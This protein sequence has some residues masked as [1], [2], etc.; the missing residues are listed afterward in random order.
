MK[1]PPSFLDEIRA[2]LPLSEVVG[3]SVKLKKEGREWRG[4]S[5]FNAEKTPSFYVNDQ[6]GFFH[7]FSAQRNGDHFAFIMETQGLSFPDAVEKL[8]GMAGLAM[9]TESPEAA[10]A[11][12]R[13]ATT[14]EAAELAAAFFEQQLRGPAGAAARAYLTE[15]GLGAEA[16][17]K[18]RLGYSPRERY[19]LR[20]HLA[21]KG[22]SAETMIEAGL[23]THGHEINVPYDFF[24]DRLMFPICDRRGRVI[25]FGGRALAKDAQPKYK[26]TSETPLFHKGSNLYNLHNARE[27]AQASGTVIAVE[28]YIDVIAMDMA[29]HKNV[30][31][32][33]GTALTPDQCELLWKMA[34]EPILC[35]DGDKA[36]RK[37]AFR[38]VDTALPLIGAGKSLRFALLPE[39]QDPDDLARS[40][41]GAA[42]QAVLE[43]SKPLAE[44][45]FLREAEA[46]PLDTPERRAALE[47]RLRD[48]AGQIRD[49]V[50]RRHYFIDLRERLAGL[51]ARM[52]PK[53]ETRSYV[54]GQGNRPEAL[55]FSRAPLS[56]SSAL[57]QSHIFRPDTPPLREALILALLLNHPGLLALHDEDVAWLEFSN[58][59]ASRLRDA[60]IGLIEPDLAPDHLRKKLLSSGFQKFLTVLATNATILTLWCVRPEA[61]ESDADKVLRQA[62]ALHHKQRALNRE[63]RLAEAVLAEEP[64]TANLAVLADIRAQLS[65][66]DGAEAMVEGFGAQSGKEDKSV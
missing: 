32:G 22:C 31:A 35:F 23:L 16:R 44:M 49:E 52:R 29:G 15:R 1:F 39:G 50:L 57:L 43:A 38:A 28:G 34:E 56:L 33:L 61:H 36:G 66:L 3:Q 65:A 59:G 37:A 10:A 11:E 53:A 58:E 20:D 55:T 47:R 21:S 2:R 27:A 51:F 9:P 26:N 42:I 6:K 45:L 60:L 19:A 30:V 40:G 13:R 63:L 7:D 14:I 41:G 64:S 5:P 8:A 54:K 18:F 46:Q 25:A 17:Q 12:R 4:L 24:R 62:L 48:S